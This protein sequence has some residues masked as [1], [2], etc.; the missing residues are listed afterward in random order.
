VVCGK[1]GRFTSAEDEKADWV[2]EISFFKN[3][4]HKELPKSREDDPLIHLKM[5]ELDKERN[6][7]EENEE[8][9]KRELE[10]AVP[11]M[12]NLNSF[13]MVAL[14]QECKYEKLAE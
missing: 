13:T 5:M 2:K 14:E 1:A 3:K 4:C 8:C 9:K 12:G 6:D 10:L 11:K 7:L